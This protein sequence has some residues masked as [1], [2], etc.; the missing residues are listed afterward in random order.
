ML[1]WYFNLRRSAYVS[2]NRCAGVKDGV[3]TVVCGVTLATAV[4]ASHGGASQRRR[5]CVQGAATGVTPT[6]GVYADCGH[7]SDPLKSRTLE[8][9]DPGVGFIFST[10]R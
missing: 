6:P 5:L 1:C 7:V 8:L 9:I 4:T 3:S 2:G 10:P